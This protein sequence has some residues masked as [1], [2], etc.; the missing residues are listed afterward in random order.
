MTFSL[1][2][3]RIGIRFQPLRPSSAAKSGKVRANCLSSQARWLHEQEKLAAT[4]EK[5]KDNPLVRR[6]FV[7]EFANELAQGLQAYGDLS[8]KESVGKTQQKAISAQ[9][10]VSLS[11]RTG[12]TVETIGKIMPAPLARLMK[13]LRFGGHAA[14]NWQNT[15][16]DTQS[17]KADTSYRLVAAAVRRTLEDGYAFADRYGNDAPLET[18]AFRIASAVSSYEEQAEKAVDEHIEMEREAGK[19]DLTGATPTEYKTGG[20]LR[21][22]VSANR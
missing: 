21:S 14:L 3:N 5:F 6:A 18:A 19:T 13:S 16:F 11:R 7:T 1:C 22:S 17:E 15:H 10:G 2:S 9:A 12:P 20:R 8:Y 4:L